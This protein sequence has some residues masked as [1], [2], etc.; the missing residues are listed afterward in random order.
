MGGGL[1]SGDIDNVMR[2]LAG[3]GVVLALGAAALI[4]WVLLRG[5]PA[6]LVPAVKWVLLVG[7]FVLPS[8]A[9]LSGNVVGFHKTK[10]SCSQC[11]TMD[12]WVNDM[13]DPRS[14][15]L[16][17]KH[18][19]NRWINEDQC[20]TCHTGYGLAGNVR[21]KMSGVSHV[22]HHYVTGVPDEIRIRRPFPPETCLHC[23]AE[24]AG[25]LKI[26]QHVDPEMKPKI[27]T[28]QLS[29]FECHEAPHP[30]KKK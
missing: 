16:A 9:M 28:G 8:M 3:A 27:L 12:P 25:Y 1:F 24:A 17:A 7:L 29:C 23:H 5:R 21:A 19:Q 4:V 13:K 18:Y 10:Q 26:E 30:R 2:W 14:K 11:H 15:T 22:L 6:K 20:Y